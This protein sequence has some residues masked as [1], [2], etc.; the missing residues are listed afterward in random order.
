[1]SAAAQRLTPYL[2]GVGLG[3]LSWIAFALARDPLGIT[4]ALARVGQP[5]AALAL[6]AEAAARNSYWRPA[7]FAW[8]YGVLFLIGVLAGSFAAALMFGR[9][10]FE[11]VPRFW[12]ERFG[13]SALKRFAA[14]FLAGALLMYGARLAGGCTSGHGLSGGLQLAASS[15]LFL[16]VIFASG[17]AASALLYGRGARR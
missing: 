8:D 16:I 11:A 6:G 1:M 2:V 15:W 4:T 5:V 14:A 12:R 17:I 9:F 13:G 7:P 10:R 3:V